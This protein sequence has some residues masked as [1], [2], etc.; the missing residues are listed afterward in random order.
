M[1]GRGGK[2]QDSLLVRQEK[3]V[4]RPSS[5]KPYARISLACIELEARCDFKMSDGFLQ[6]D[7]M[8]TRWRRGA[9][10]RTRNEV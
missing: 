4:A 2:E 5:D 3:T 8:K 6:F 9:G 7:G 1:S 10:S